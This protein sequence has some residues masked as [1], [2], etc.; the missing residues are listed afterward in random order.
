MLLTDYRL[1]AVHTFQ[2]RTL[3]SLGYRT[4]VVLSNASGKEPQARD[5]LVDVMREEV[6]FLSAVQDHYVEYY[7]ADGFSA[8]LLYQAALFNYGKLGPQGMTII[9]APK[10]YVSEEV[11]TFLSLMNCSPLV[12][13]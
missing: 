9:Q 13:Y 8:G 5:G 6:Y 4:R 2:V 1:D 11:D 3:S 10:V 7:R 12:E